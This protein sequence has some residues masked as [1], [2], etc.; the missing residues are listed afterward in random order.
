VVMLDMEAGMRSLDYVSAC[1]VA[2]E[3][4]GSILALPLRLICCLFDCEKRKGEEDE[5]ECVLYPPPHAQ[6]Q[7]SEIP[8]YLPYKTHRLL[9][10]RWCVIGAVG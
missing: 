2:A 10:I 1:P 5:E 3:S 4:F 8:C 6:P 7:A 9:I